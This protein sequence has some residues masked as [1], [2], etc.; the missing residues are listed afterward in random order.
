M[1]NLNSPTFCK[2]FELKNT[3]FFYF[4]AKVKF[5]YWQ[6]ESL[7]YFRYW[8]TQWTQCFCFFSYLLLIWC[9]NLD[10]FIFKPAR[11]CWIIFGVWFNRL[12]S[13]CT[14]AITECMWL[15]WRKQQNIC[16]NILLTKTNAATDSITV[17]WVVLVSRLLLFNVKAQ[18]HLQD[19]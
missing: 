8:L 4:Y 15:Y 11:N 2:L 14:C 17:L 3:C 19:V 1:Y 13:V 7:P 18:S 9:N 16:I 6:V 12:L 5:Y 10:P